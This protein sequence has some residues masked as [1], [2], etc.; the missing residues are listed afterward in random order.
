M[1]RP[2]L[3]SDISAALLGKHSHRRPAGN[4]FP[5]VRISDVFRLLVSHMVGM[6][7]YTVAPN[8]NGTGFDVAVSAG[9][10]RLETTL[11][12]AN[13][14]DAKAWVVQATRL[15]K[16]WMPVPSFGRSRFP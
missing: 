3:L 2:E 4:K 14:A 12:F 13:E 16:P 1:R 6:T 5:H 15:A 7:T 8:A 10:G 11:G 9:G